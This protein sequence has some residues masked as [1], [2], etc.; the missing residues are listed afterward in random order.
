MQE[1]RNS[2]VRLRA[3]RVRLPG[4]HPPIGFELFGVGPP[5]GVGR[6]D[7]PG[8]DDDGGAGGDEV[9]LDGC[10]FLGF[11]DGEGDGGEDARRFV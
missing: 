1:R 4:P 5:E 9:A 8:G 3:S 2:V 11:T 7:G 6:V 10:I